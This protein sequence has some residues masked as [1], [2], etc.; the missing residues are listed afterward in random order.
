MRT[1]A[2]LLSL[3]SAGVVSAA[4]VPKPSGDA[5]VS[6]DA[7]LEKLFTRS[8]AIHGGLTEGPTPAPDGSIYFSD[9]PLG[10][11]KGMI[12]RFDPKTK[13]TTVFAKD[14]HKSNGLKF[15]AKGF[16]I[17]C[18]GSDVGGRCVGRWDI[19]SRKRTVIADRYQGKRF[20]APNDLA[21]DRKGRIYFT[22]PRYLGT[23][24]R[25]LEHRA[26]YRIDTD[27]KVIEVTHTLEK[28][29]GIALSPDQKYLYVADHNNGT[30]RID[31]T[32]PA[33]KLGAMKVY[34]FSL[35]DDGLVH[36][37]GKVIVDFG[38][39][40]GSDGM[41]VDARGNI[42]LAA[43]SLKRP[44][45]LVVD[46]DG[47]EVAFIPTGPSQSGA[48]EPRGIPSNCCFGVGDESKMLYVT[49]DVSLYRIPLKVE[50]YH[51]PF[52]K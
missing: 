3:L 44:G 29:N 41:T 9:I 46:P 48:K 25:E 14:S 27:G 28:P 26:V 4:D 42:Y 15:D 16:L 12:L 34:R 19:K 24:P 20:N 43:R 23:E 40:A 50:G 21:I 47:K 33:P 49:V 31:P 17:A 8:A 5:I 36:G 2:L 6:P 38:T 37:S 35:G 30:D 18:E 22:D 13:K 10:K 45:I 52:E 32:A 39:E 11:D 1:V 51:V 7:K